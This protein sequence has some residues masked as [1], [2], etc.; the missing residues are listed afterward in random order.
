MSLRKW[1]LRPWMLPLA[2]SIVVATPT[3]LYSAPSDFN[4]FGQTNLVS[5]IP[6]LANFTDPDLVNPWGVSFSSGSPFWV[7]DNGTGLST[8]YNTQG[9]KQGL[10]VS[11]LGPGGTGSGTPTG[12][13][14]NPKSSDFNGAHFI[15][16]TEDGTINAWSGGTTA[17]QPV[18]NFPG[19]VYKGLALANNN[20][21]N[22][23]YAAN[24]RGGTVDVFDNH[25]NPVGSFTDANLPMGYAP[26]NIQSFGG[27]LYVTFALQNAAKH[28]DVAGP[29]HGF[30]DVFNPDGSFVRRLVS[31]GALNSPWGL[32]VAP[33]D[34]GKFSNDLLVGNFG[35]GKINAFDPMTGAPIGTVDGTNGQPLVIDGLWAIIFGNGGN[36]G[37]KDVLYFT[38]GINHEADGLFGAISTPEPGTLTLLG[39]GFASLIGYGWRKRKRTA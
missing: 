1:A 31:M 36:G 23:L 9:V 25:F 3:L 26:F 6:G 33:G 20:G 29:G 19:A 30:I 15:F 22:F 39:S 34:F 35:D 12:Q 21:A 10:V 5:D 7:S 2:V 38:A 27:Q 16:A 4:S 28:D 13:V 17:A 37:S 18:D 14:F 11:I 24:F 8:L 32:A